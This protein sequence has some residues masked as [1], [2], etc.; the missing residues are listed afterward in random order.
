[1]FAYLPVDYANVRR[2][3]ASIATFNSGKCRLGL[4]KLRA[5]GSEC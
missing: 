1:M 3:A 5:R 2:T 4:R